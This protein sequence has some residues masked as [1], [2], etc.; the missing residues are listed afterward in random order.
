MRLAGHSVHIKSSTK[1]RSIYKKTKVRERFRHRYHLMWDPAKKAKEAGLVVSATDK[2]G[3]I[4]N[5]IEMDNK[6]WMVGVQY[7]PEYCSRPDKPHPIYESFVEAMMKRKL[8]K[9]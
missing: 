1:L 3:E 8:R 2:T 4:I 9:D 5:A 6:F 7:H